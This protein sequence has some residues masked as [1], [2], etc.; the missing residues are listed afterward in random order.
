MVAAAGEWGAQ[1]A[2]KAAA[3]AAQEAAE[4]KQRQ[5]FEAYMQRYEERYQQVGVDWCLIGCAWWWSC[6][7]H[8]PANPADEPQ[9]TALN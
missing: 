9:L 5:E 4:A 6:A 1:R 2:E 8:S 7:A 3:R